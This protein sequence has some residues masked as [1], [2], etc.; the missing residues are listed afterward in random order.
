MALKLAHVDEATGARYPDAYWKIDYVLMRSRDEGASIFVRAYTDETARRGGKQPLPVPAREYHV[1]NWVEVREW[2]EEVPPVA[3]GEEQAPAQIVRSE[4]QI[5]HNDYDEYFG[6]DVFKAGG[7]TPRG[8]AY[9]YL[10]TQ[11][12]WRGATAA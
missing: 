7:C 11:E 4:Q 9:A 6:D 1:R 10:A 3:E 8:Q 2:A 5:P 12:D